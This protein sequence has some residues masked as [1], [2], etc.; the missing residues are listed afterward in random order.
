ML[1]VAL[2]DGRLELGIRNYMM[3][4]ILMIEVVVF[5]RPYS[6]HDKFSKRKLL[7]NTNVEV[8]CLCTLERVNTVT[9]LAVHDDLY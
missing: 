2:S 8:P 6:V 9:G 4:S 3:I 7:V 1:F 5:P